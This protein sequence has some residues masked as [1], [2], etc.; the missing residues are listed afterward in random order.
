M[1]SNRSI[2]ARITMGAG[3]CLFLAVTAVATIAFISLRTRATAEQR[4]R[5]Q[6]AARSE[7][8]AFATRVKLAMGTATG[9]CETLRGIKDEEVLLEIN[10][11]SAISILGNAI[12]ENPDLLAVFTCWEP[13][14]FDELD[15]GFAGEPGSDAE[16]RFVARWQRVPGGEKHL[17]AQNGYAAPGFYDETR[18]A[19]LTTRLARVSAGN[20]GKQERLVVR[21]CKAVAVG[22]TF[23]GIVGVDVDL[24]FAAAQVTEFTADN[25]GWQ[26]TI[27]SP[28][29]EVAAGPTTAAMPAP[30]GAALAEHG[31]A[32]WQHEDQVVFAATA[33][34]DARAGRPWVATVQTPTAGL[35]AAATAVAFQMGWV[36]LLAAVLGI[37]MVLWTAR[38]ILAPLGGV[39]D[40]MDEIASGG[41]DLSRRLPVTR[42]DEIGRVADAFNR[43]AASIG[44]IVDRVRSNTASFASR[45]GAVSDSSS[46]LNERAREQRSVLDRVNERMQDLTA[47]A[48]ANR[49]LA[50]LAI[51][52]T[53]RAVQVLED[54]LE[55]MQRVTAT[56]S[57][58]RDA[59]RSTEAVMTAIDGIAFQTNLLALNAAV[60]AARAGEHGR[61]FA[62]VAEEVRAL[63]QRSAEAA[64]SNGTTIAQ[65]I[66]SSQQGADLVAR[67]QHLLGDLRT[68]FTELR[69]SIDEI[70]AH[71][72]TQVTQISDVSAASEEL[73]AS[74]HDTGAMASELAQATGGI[75]AAAAEITALFAAFKTAESREPHHREEM[76]R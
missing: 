29:G 33:A 9:V 28:A 24:G 42:G 54:S 71:S 11:K 43:F 35:T 76:T 64:R 14:A 5:L 7:A 55:Q 67:L 53:G 37:A 16:G 15:G 63:A 65:S 20:D 50:N 3:L 26:L 8:R 1:T 66:E 31:Q 48:E 17:T 39:A 57:Q 68:T 75:D 13:D 34:I 21:C 70:N 27:T 38:R 45:T 62:V 10:R 44:E 30:A 4:Q 46:S 25:L 22:E 58:V 6:T 47:A 23:Y 36:G 32:S 12:E 51:D 59:S 56:M 40:A 74:A 49:E 19:G 18:A 52:H 69:A 72:G 2:A 61:G 60:E 73:A 41:G